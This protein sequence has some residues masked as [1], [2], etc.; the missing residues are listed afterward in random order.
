MGLRLAIISCFSLFHSL[1]RQLL[2]KEPRRSLQCGA[3]FST[4]GIS[5]LI[6]SPARSL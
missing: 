3:Y 6:R 2:P 4:V 1:V 5:A